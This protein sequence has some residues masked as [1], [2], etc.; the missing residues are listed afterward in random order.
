MIET[1][2]KQAR[3]EKR[4]FPE[5]VRGVCPDCGSDV[6]SNVYYVPGHNQQGAYLLVWEC[7]ESLTDDPTCNYRKLI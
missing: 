6:V 3:R 5:W 1:G 7:W 2:A 4:P